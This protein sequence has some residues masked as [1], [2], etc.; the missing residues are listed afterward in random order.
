MGVFTVKVPKDFGNKKLQWTLIANG[1]TNSITLQTFPVYIVEPYK[2]SW[3]N[4]TPPTVKFA[5]SGPGF[6]GPP[7]GIAITAWTSCRLP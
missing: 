5:P 2:A 7:Q 6:T 1:L 4:A 3:N